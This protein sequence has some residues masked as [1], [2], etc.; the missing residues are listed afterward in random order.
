MRTIQFWLKFAKIFRLHWDYHWSYHHPKTC[1]KVQAMQKI[2]C[3]REKARFG[4][5][6]DSGILH[7]Y[8]VFSPKGSG[9][10]E[11]FVFLFGGSTNTHAGIPEGWRMIDSDGAEKRGDVVGFLEGKRYLFEGESNKLLAV[12]EE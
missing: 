12:A 5:D 1:Q 10:E 8:L 3:L 4:I 9:N 11:E 6:E 7:E 2:E